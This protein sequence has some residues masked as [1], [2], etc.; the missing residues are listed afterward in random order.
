MSAA[1]ADGEYLTDDPGAFS[2]CAY[3]RGGFLPENRWQTVRMPLTQIGVEGDILGK[4]WIR[5]S[6]GNPATVFIDEV[7]LVA[8]Q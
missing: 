6:S 3:A 7:K 5:F 1:S 8:K 4:F 2:I